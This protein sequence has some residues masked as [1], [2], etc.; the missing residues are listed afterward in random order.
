M[1]LFNFIRQCLAAEMKFLQ[2]AGAD[3]MGMGPALA[4]SNSA[5]EVLHKLDDLRRRT[6]V[7]TD[8]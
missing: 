5:A 4:I 6:Q 3:F 7:R 8:F 2:A 1:Q